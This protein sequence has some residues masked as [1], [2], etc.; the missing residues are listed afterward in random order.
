MK[1]SK[2]DT[3]GEGAPAGK[4]NSRKKTEAAATPSSG[5]APQVVSPA[6]TASDTRSEAR[7]ADREVPLPHT[8][9]LETVAEIE[10]PYEQ[11]SRRAYEIY[12]QRGAA[13]GRALDDWLEAERDVRRYRSPEARGRTESPDSQPDSQPDAASQVR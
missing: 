9:V 10:L 1:K 2:K 5:E 11:I 12:V 6:A 4:R 7:F 8:T 3:A 13:P